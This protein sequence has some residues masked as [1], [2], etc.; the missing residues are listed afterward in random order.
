MPAFTNNIY[1]LSF[2]QS[3]DL[4]KKLNKIAVG[5]EWITSPGFEKAGLGLDFKKPGYPGQIRFS[6]KYDIN[7][8]FS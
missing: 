5:S 2:G 8:F 7:A 6:K 4:I 3:C 1:L